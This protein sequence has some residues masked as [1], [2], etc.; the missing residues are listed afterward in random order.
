MGQIMQL[1]N[2]IAMVGISSR[3]SEDKLFF[4][5]F[6]VSKNGKKVYFCGDYWDEDICNVAESTDFIFVWEEFKI[7]FESKES[8]DL[9][10]AS[11][12]F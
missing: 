12:L 8:R 4:H 10:L 1:E 11:F 5:I 7:M 9:L 3:L 6:A 2:L